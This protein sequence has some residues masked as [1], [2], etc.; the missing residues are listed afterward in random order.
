VKGHQFGGP[1]GSQKEDDDNDD[2][3]PEDELTIPT[4]DNPV[5]WSAVNL[6]DFGK[7]IENRILYRSHTTM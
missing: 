4:D 2:L 3:L 6:E 5:R 1:N 7:C